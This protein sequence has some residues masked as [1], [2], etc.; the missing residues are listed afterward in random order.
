MNGYRVLVAQAHVHGLV[1]LEA[2]C[3][4]HGVDIVWLDALSVVALNAQISVCPKIGIGNALYPARWD[5]DSLNRELMS[6][7]GTFAS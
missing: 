6:T 4:F 2:S 5:F 7:W 1:V 3:V